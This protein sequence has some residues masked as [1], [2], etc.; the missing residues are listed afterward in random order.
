MLAQVKTRD[1]KFSGNIIRFLLHSS[2]ISQKVH[3]LYSCA[4]PKQG[5]QSCRNY[6]GNIFSVNARTAHKRMGRFRIQFY[7]VGENR[8]LP[9]VKYHSSFMT[10]TVCHRVVL[11]KKLPVDGRNSEL[12]VSSKYS[13]SIQLW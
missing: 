10:V 4:N 2:I 1:M 13:A 9:V 6:T 8:K 12:I 7:Q 5:S 3:T 11:P